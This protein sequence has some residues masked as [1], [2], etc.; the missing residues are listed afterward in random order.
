MYF[1]LQ[2]PVVFLTGAWKTIYGP[3]DFAQH[4]G[5][6]LLPLL[7][8]WG[9]PEVGSSYCVFQPGIETEEGWDEEGRQITVSWYVVFDMHRVVQV[10]WYACAQGLICPTDVRIHVGACLA[11]FG[12]SNLAAISCATLVFYLLLLL[13]FWGAPEVVPSLHLFSVP[14]PRLGARS[15][16]RR[17]VGLWVVP[18]SLGSPQVPK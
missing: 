4:T 16:G 3:C 1:V 10:L 5:V 14:R 6:Y 2:P 15:P 11:V 12:P 17:V 9:A 7:R 8:F 13:H 18:K